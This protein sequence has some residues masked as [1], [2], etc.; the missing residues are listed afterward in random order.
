MKATE[1]QIPKLTGQL[2][3]HQKAFASLSSE[4]AQWVIANT[5]AAIGLFVTA[6]HTVEEGD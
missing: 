4:D 2:V 6:A 5:V 1:Q 3:E